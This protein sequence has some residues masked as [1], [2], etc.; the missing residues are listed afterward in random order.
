M[1]RAFLVAKSATNHGWMYYKVLQ[2]GIVVELGYPEY[3][4]VH[5]GPVSEQ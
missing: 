1:A 4:T 3:N 5:T 2:T